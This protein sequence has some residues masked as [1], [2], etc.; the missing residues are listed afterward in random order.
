MPV[1]L[2]AVVKTT[3]EIFTRYRRASVDAN[4]NLEPISPI[5]LEAINTVLHIQSHLGDRL[6]MVCSGDRQSCCYHISIAK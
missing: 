4:S 3:R 6:S 2:L 1:V 5:C